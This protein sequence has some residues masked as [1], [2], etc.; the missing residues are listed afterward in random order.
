M[1]LQARHSARCL[2]VTSGNTADGARVIQYACGLGTNQQWQ[3]QDAGSGYVR[4]V[5]RHSGRCLDVISASTSDGA[6]LAQYGCNGGAN[7]QW[8]WRTP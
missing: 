3:V 6:R 4:L 1:Q 5:A 8:L 2:D 7:Q